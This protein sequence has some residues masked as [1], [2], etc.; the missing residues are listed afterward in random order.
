MRNQDKRK[1]RR[2]AKKGKVRPPED[3]LHD[4]A[5]ETEEKNKNGFLSHSKSL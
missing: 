2:K 4:K 5:K 1:G 3:P